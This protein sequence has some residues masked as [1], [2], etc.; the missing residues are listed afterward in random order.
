MFQNSDD[1]TAVICDLDHDGVR[2]VPQRR[3]YTSRHLP[4]RN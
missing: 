4:Q 3:R 1:K 2:E